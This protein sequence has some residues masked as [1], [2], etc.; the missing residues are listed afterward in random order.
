MHTFGDMDGG[1]RHELYIMNSVQ[2]L[3]SISGHFELIPRN[4]AAGA[5]SWPLTST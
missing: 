3:T 2:N 1:Y 5:C 4:N